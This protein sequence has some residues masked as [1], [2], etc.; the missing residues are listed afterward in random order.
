MTEARSAAG[1]RFPYLLTRRTRAISVSTR[2]LPSGD[3]RSTVVIDQHP[4]ADS[5]RA[6]RLV[7]GLIAGAVLS[8]IAPVFGVPATGLL[9]IAISSAIT[10][11]IYLCFVV[12]FARPLNSAWEV[13]RSLQSAGSKE[14]RMAYLNDRSSFTYLAD[15]PA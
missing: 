1:R 8:V 14:I 6:A 13:P 9:G 3:A 15:M 11:G 2:R 10:F 4:L 5:A 12:D 7:L